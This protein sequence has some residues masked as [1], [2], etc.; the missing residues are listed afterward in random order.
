MSIFEITFIK[1]NKEIDYEK[2]VFNTL[3]AI[4]AKI[5]INMF[6]FLITHI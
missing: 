5:D 4:H 6:I 2:V 3:Y 1:Y